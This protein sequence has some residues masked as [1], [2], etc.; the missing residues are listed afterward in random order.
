MALKSDYDNEEIERDE[1]WDGKDR[2]RNYK[3]TDI[4]DAKITVKDII[5]ISVFVGGLV[6]SWVNLNNNLTTITIKQEETFKYFEKRIAD[7]ETKI[8]ENKDNIEVINQQQNKEIV[9]IKSSIEDLD[10]TVSRVYQ[11]VVRSKK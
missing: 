7:L 8:K 9:D 11:E 5:G 6:A 3:T 4:T 1:S 10:R 2:R